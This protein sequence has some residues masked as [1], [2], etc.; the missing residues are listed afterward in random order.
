LLTV[1]KRLNDLISKQGYTQKRHYKATLTV[2]DVTPE[3]KSYSSPVPAGSHPPYEYGCEVPCG[4]ATKATRYVYTDVSTFH[5]E[6]EYDYNFTRYQTEH[7]QLLGLLDAFGVNLN[8]AIIW[9]AI[10]WSFVVDWVVN[11][12][13]WLN[14]RRV[15]NMEPVI[16]IHNYLW[17]WTARRRIVVYREVSHNTI[18]HDIGGIEHTTEPGVPMPVVTETLYKRVV[19]MPTSG[20]IASSGLSLKEFSL[21]AAL[22]TVRGSHHKRSH[23]QL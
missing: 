14:D 10:P 3:T 16:N 21:G 5:A 15:L 8:A 17:S 12:S 2:P 23:S 22:V 13:S 1:K 7:A 4:V 19:E 11:V 6:I 9:N 20:S 18:Y